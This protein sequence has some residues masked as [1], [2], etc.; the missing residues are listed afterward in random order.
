[1]EYAA[2]EYEQRETTAWISLD[3]PAALNALNDELLTELEHA[4]YRAE[5]AEGVR[6]VVIEGNGDAFSSG[7]DISDAEPD[8][9]TDEKV[10]DQ[11]THLEAIFSARLPVIAAVDG[12]AVAGGCNLAIVCDLTF[13]TEGSDF[14]YPDMHF[15]EPP[16][17]FVLPFVTDSLKDAR[18]LL[19]SGKNVD[20]RTAAEMGLVNDVVPEG[21]LQARVEEELDHIRKTP[22]TALTMVKAMINDVQETQGYRR[23]GRVEELVGT[24]SMETDAPERFREIRDEEGLQAALDWMHGTDKP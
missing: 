19:Y 11:R 13:A 9:T 20:A 4:V 16:P 12:A 3:R 18:E 21:E 23:Y 8:A 2:I 6:A 10:H 15:G 7:Y 1:M 14:G 5:D 17:K 24:L 22:G